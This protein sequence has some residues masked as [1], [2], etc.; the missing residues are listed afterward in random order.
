MKSRHHPTSPRDLFM[1]MFSIIALYIT[2]T[3]LGKLI[4]DYLNFYLP[5][6][7]DSMYGMYGNLA[8]KIRWPLA[9][10]IIL[11][12]LYLWVSWLL[13]KDLIRHPEK[14]DMGVRKWLMYLT[15]FL[16]AIAVVIDLVTLVFYYLG[17]EI[18]LRFV[19]KILAVLIIGVIIFAIYLWD[20]KSDISPLQH[21]KM[22]WFVRGSALLVFLVV[23]L[24]LVFAG[25][26]QVQRATRL[27]Q[28]RVF[29]L[30][31]IQWQVI[32]HWQT[33]EEVPAKL[34]EL[35][36]EFTGYTLPFDPES[37]SGYEYNKTGDMSFELCAFFE[38]STS[39]ENSTS[40]YSRPL[41]PYQD[42]IWDHGTGR[43]CFSRTIDPKQYPPFSK[44]SVPTK[45]NY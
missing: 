5:D 23:I 8:E 32:N 28:Q 33:K 17:G 12:P 15:L 19:L 31:N 27:D 22:K 26:P 18:T 6:A 35:Q 45:I 43:V 25:S 41:V 30:Q 39:E 1:W 13:Q 29:D 4:F 11:F 14:R 38:T 24:G 44:E 34:E 40:K 37:R 16:T 7:L 2:V 36:D 20:L 10:L 9:L 21:P 3:A 42:E